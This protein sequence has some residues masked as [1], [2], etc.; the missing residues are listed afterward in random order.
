MIIYT[1]VEFQFLIKDKDYAS[2]W[3]RFFSSTHTAV[4]FCELF[5]PGQQLLVKCSLFEVQSLLLCMILTGK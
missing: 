3:V 1:Y 5:L 2:F 4:C